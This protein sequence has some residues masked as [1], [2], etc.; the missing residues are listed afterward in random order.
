MWRAF[1]KSLGVEAAGCVWL[2]GQIG[3]KKNLLKMCPS[4]CVHGRAGGQMHGAFVCLKV[5]Y[6]SIVHQSLPS[7]PSF[8]LFSFSLRASFIKVLRSKG[9]A[10]AWGCL[11]SWGFDLWPFYVTA[12]CHPFILNLTQKY[13]WIQSRAGSMREFNSRPSSVYKEEGLVW[14]QL[15]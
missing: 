14:C 3:E 4:C 13:E 15:L 8:L 6:W 10:A 12:P 1:L 5:R 11:G 7:S 9:A 2:E